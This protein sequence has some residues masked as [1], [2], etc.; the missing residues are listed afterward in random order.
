VL[1]EVFM[2]KVGLQNKVIGAHIKSPIHF[3]KKEL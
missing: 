2:L 1:L 3:Y